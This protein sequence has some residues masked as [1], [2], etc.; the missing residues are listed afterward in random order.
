MLILILIDAVTV[1]SERPLRGVCLLSSRR[2][3]GHYGSGLR[4]SIYFPT[5]G[6]GSQ[7]KVLFLVSESDMTDSNNGGS[8]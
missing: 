2:A 7:P 6:L 8:V 1:A 5:I 3:G 4:P